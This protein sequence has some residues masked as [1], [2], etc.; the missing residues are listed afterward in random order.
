MAT[1][2]E[3][4]PA[5][6][7]GDPA[8]EIRDV[9]KSFAGVTVLRGVDLTV[10]RGEIHGLI[11]PNGS[12][13]STLVK[14]LAGFHRPDGNPTIRVNGHE[15]ATPFSVADVR[16]SGMGFVHQ[17]LALV[18]ESSAADNLGF[19]AA[20]FVRAPGGRIRW[21]KHNARARELFARVGLDIDP[22]TLV[23]DLG[24]AER[25]LVAIAR[26]LNEFRDESLLILDE[27]TASLPQQEVDRLFV[28]LRGLAAS[29]TALI[30]I[31]HR[32][33]ELI[34]LTDRVTV[35]RDGAVIASV[36]TADTTHDG[37]AE[38][39]LGAVETRR[40]EDAHAPAADGAAGGEILRLS[41]VTTP[42]LLPT[43]LTLHAGEVLVL[44][45]PV[46]CGASE[47]GRLLYGETP[48][49]HGTVEVDGRPFDPATAP[50][51]AKQLGIAYLPADRQG[52]SSF[53]DLTVLENMLVTDWPTLANGGR[54]SP[55]RARREADRMIAELRVEPPDSGR[56]FR[57]LSGGNQQKALIAKWLR[58]GPRVLVIDEPTQGIDIRTRGEIY[59][60]VRA[61]AAKGLAVVWITSDFE[62]ASVIGDRVM[63]F[64]GGRHQTTLAGDDVTPDLI[65]RSSLLEVG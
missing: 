44:T 23:G 4:D 21:R 19:S 18:W 26:A 42:K 57:T 3:R 12:G 58:L 50:A 17:D 13:K 52:L 64:V 56:I 34:A 8:L 7:G 11:G 47:V 45:G 20:G 14:V 46:G 36:D 49:V 29:G 32:L 31:S 54:V 28:A 61:E 60:R 30:Y 51:S 22:Q 15:L 65:G 53:Q 24:P 59:E 55:R 6:P 48:V 10:Q 9:R 41:G 5:R 2:E 35:L 37:M 40:P 25:T 43:D 39:M 27:P 63:V 38:L 33:P 62:E 1:D 16:Q